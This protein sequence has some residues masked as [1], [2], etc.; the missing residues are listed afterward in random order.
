M[1]EEALAQHQQN[2]REK[3]ANDELSKRHEVIAERWDSQ[4]WQGFEQFLL[5]EQLHQLHAL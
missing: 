1:T 4:N 2:K 3:D 5:V